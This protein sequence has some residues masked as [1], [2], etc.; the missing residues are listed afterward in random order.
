[1]PSYHVNKFETTKLFYDQYLY[2]LT[3]VNPLASI[4]RGKNL[5]YA[6]Q[7]L[8]KLQLQYETKSNLALYYAYGART[9]N[10]SEQDFTAAKI[11]LVEFNMHKDYTLR[12][13]NPRMAIYS[14]NKKWINMLLEKPLITT[15][16]WAPSSDNINLLIKNNIIITDEN[17]DYNY[18]ITL[19]EKVNTQFYD[20]LINNSHKVKIGDTC[21]RC[22]KRGDYV[23]GFYFY[24]KGEK[25]LSIVNLMIGGE[26]ARIDNIVNRASKDK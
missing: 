6:R 22:I 7:Q 15:E 3:V 9:I 10:L 14:N 25:T 20:W 23:R 26:I 12:I 1:M 2:K 8:D 24:L 21:L 13:E 16:I 18:K 4:F 19:K 11:L 5:T 17:F